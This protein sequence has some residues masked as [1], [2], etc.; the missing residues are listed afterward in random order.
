MWRQQLAFFTFHLNVSMWKKGFSS[1][2]IP[3]SMHDAELAL[4]RMSRET[5]KGEGSILARVWHFK[6]VLE[7]A[8]DA[9]VRWGLSI[10]CAVLAV[11]HG[12]R[13]ERAGSVLSHIYSRGK[14]KRD[15]DIKTCG[16]GRWPDREFELSKSEYF[17]ALIIN[18]KD[19]E[20]WPELV[21]LYRTLQ[22]RG[23]VRV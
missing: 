14:S 1:T 16:E 11:S 9:A 13:W 4:L 10:F 2:F 22:L 21:V 20:A 12:T 18:K 3:Y 7:R 17:V 19:E 23:R 6:D 5:A 8:A 15:G